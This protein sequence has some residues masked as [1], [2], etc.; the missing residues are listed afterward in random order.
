MNKNVNVKNYIKISVSLGIAVIIF[1]LS[2]FSDDYRLAILHKWDDRFCDT[3]YQSEDV[4]YLPITIIGIDDKTMDKIGQPSTWSRQIYADLVNKLCSENFAPSV[5][6][7]DILFTGNKYTDG[8][9]QN[10]DPGDLAFA[11]AVKNAGNVIVGQEVEYEE[12]VQSVDGKMKVVSYI[13]GVSRPYAELL[14]VSGLGVVNENPEANNVVRKVMPVVLN[15]GQKM[16]CLALASLKKFVNYCRQN[17]KYG[18]SHPQFA[19]IDVDAYSDMVNKEFRFS[20]SADANSDSFASYIPLIDILDGTRGTED[21]KN[22]IVLV[23][24]YAPGLYDSFTVPISS[25]ASNLKDTMYGVEIHANII[26]AL[27]N[28]KI[29]TDA[30]AEKGP[31]ALISLAFALVSALFCFFMFRLKIRKGAVLGILLIILD[32]VT[33]KILYSNGT[34]LYILVP[35][36]AVVV[37]YIGF[38]IF[39]YSRTK[40]EKNKIN[41]AFKLYV[42][43]EIVDEVAADGDFKLQLGGRNKDI[44]VL[45]VDIRGFTTMSESLKPE[46]VVEVLNEYFAIVTDAIFKNKGTLDKF[47]GDAAMAVFNS[48]FDLD[49]YVYRAVCTARDIAAGSDKIREKFLERFGKTVNYGIGVNCGEATIGNIGSPFRMDYTAIGDTVNTASRLESNA[50]AGTILISEEVKTRLGDRIKTEEVGEIPLK[51]KKVGIMVYKVLEVL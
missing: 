41:K 25:K 51:G 47:I 10:V 43:P 32:I 22:Q 45:F 8:G 11:E 28:G 49:D 29:Q 35:V 46:E 27:A 33:G 31:R 4:S 7:F 9:M 34:Y 14:D 23:G 20:Y 40:L 15:D 38:I 6:T 16:D 37:I 19:A 3:I 30:A 13:S 21:L 2:F 5:I 17:E 44:A 26:Q 12:A 39:F 24:A 18:S 1:L 48:P 36:I 50:P 42:A